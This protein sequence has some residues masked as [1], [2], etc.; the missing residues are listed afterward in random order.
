MQY[1]FLIYTTETPDQPP[2]EEI[3]RIKSR[4]WAVM[5]DANRLDKF[6][7]AVPLAP[8]TSAATVR[9]QDGRR[10][11][12]DGPFA[13]TKEQLAGFYILDCADLNEALEW[14]ARIPTSCGGAP[15]SIE[16]R[17]VQELPAR[18]APEAASVANA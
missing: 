8:A 1:M 2:P 14:A 3:E 7:A 13:E 12:T 5:D 18:T 10:L 11:I 4:H 16:V 17:P 15:G 9:V 6:V